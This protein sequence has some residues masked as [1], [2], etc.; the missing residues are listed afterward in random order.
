[1]TDGAGGLS[2]APPRLRSSL[3]SPRALPASWRKGEQEQSGLSLSGLGMK[4]SF[5]ALSPSRGIP[6]APEP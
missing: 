5:R 6:L 4:T 2:H 1:M 3:S